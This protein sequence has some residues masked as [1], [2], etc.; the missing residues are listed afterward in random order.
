MIHD[1]DDVDDVDVFSQ[2]RGH[3]VGWQATEKAVGNALASTDRQGARGGQGQGHGRRS[4]NRRGGDGDAANKDGPTRPAQDGERRQAPAGATTA[5]DATESPR[6]DGSPPFNLRQ[7][8][9]LNVN[10]RAHKCCF[11]QR[12]RT[13]IKL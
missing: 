11:G 8:L 12:I 13:I 7:E 4:S 1:E 3:C 6:G 2:G 5:T 9:R 10:A